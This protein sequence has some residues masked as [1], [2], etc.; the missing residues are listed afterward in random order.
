MIWLDNFKKRLANNT[1]YSNISKPVLLDAWSLIPHIY[2]SDKLYHT[3]VTDEDNTEIEHYY[4]A[5]DFKTHKY[6][7]IDDILEKLYEIASFVTIPK[8]LT[9]YNCDYHL[10]FLDATE[11]YVLNYYPQNKLDHSTNHLEPLQKAMQCVAFVNDNGRYFLALPMAI[12]ASEFKKVP[13]IPVINTDLATIDQIL[14]PIPLYHHDSVYTC[15]ACGLSNNN[16]LVV[17]SGYGIYD[18]ANLLASDMID[19]LTDYFDKNL[20]LELDDE[21]LPKLSLVKTN[22]FWRNSLS[23]F[24]MRDLKTLSQKDPMFKVMNPKDSLF[25]DNHMILL[26]LNI[27]NKIEELG[28]IS[29]AKCTNDQQVESLNNNTAEIYH[30]LVKAEGL[31]FVLSSMQDKTLQFYTYQNELLY[32][33]H[34]E[35]R[36]CSL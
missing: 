13:Y 3:Y 20:R 24:T 30:P 12:S 15:Y 5:S 28:F 22:N 17:R 26:Q 6:E 36:S 4:I 10:V 32:V 35:V 7:I 34:G 21:G 1:A 31:N 18:Q 8:C 29:D 19:A 2:D 14:A 16:N 11:D 27:I 9:E 33:S 25:A 23:K